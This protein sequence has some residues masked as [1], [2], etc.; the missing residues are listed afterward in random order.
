MHNRL[1]EDAIQI[2]LRD[3]VVPLYVGVY[4]HEKPNTQSVVIDVE[5]TAPLSHRYDDLKAG[6]LSLIIDYDRL[7]NFVTKVLP[8]FGH[9]P[10]L[11]SIGERIIAFCFEDTRI[12]EVRVRI[13]K[14]DILQ[15]KASVG[16]EMRRKR[17]V[18]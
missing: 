17:K 7:Y 12:E 9:V 4:D 6:S 8:T 5:V 11:E 14:P 10:L 13:S 16:I 3:C 2:Y 18:A 1:T 15:G